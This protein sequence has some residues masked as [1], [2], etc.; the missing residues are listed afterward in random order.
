MENLFDTYY[1]RLRDSDQPVFVLL[2][3]YEKLFIKKAG[4]AEIEVFTRLVKIYGRF[5]TF[6]TLTKIATRYNNI[7][8]ADGLEKLMGVIISSDAVEEKDSGSFFDSK[9]L[10]D[11]IEEIERSLSSEEKLIIPELKLETE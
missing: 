8:K 7:R 5:R 3:Y 1:E 4:R 2:E 9:V 11:Q 10:T 6:Y